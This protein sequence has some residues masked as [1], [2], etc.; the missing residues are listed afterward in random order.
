M[1]LKNFYSASSAE[2][3]DVFVC[4]IK[5]MV[6]YDGHYRIYRCPLEAETDDEGIPQGDRL[7]GDPKKVRVAI[8]TIMPVLR[9]TR[10]P[11]C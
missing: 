10:G 8:E 7:F 6:V 9:A 3:G 11:Y 4:T 5:V 1:P 2:P